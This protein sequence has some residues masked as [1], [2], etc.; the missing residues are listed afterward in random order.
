MLMH[1]RQGG[2]AGGEVS[3]DL[4]YRADISRFGGWLKSCKNF[5]IRQTGAAINRPG[6]YFMGYLPDE[7]VRLLPFVFSLQDNCV[8]AMTPQIVRFFTPQGPV[9]DKDANPYA[10]DTPYDAADLKTLYWEQVYDVLYLA[11]PNKPPKTLT[12]YAADDWKV[13]NY[14]FTQGP[15][16]P[17]DPQ[18][19]GWL[20]KE[21]QDGETKTFLNSMTYDFTS[22]DV[23]NIF[24]LRCFF[25]A[26][27]L[28]KKIQALADADELKTHMVCVG[29]GWTFKTAGT[30]NGEIILQYSEDGETWKDYQT[31]SS[32]DGGSNWS[33]TDSF[34][35]VFFLRLDATAV[36]AWPCKVDLDVLSFEYNVVGK[37]TALV[38][39]HKVQ[40]SLQDLP[41]KALDYVETLSEFTQVPITPLTSNTSSSMFSLYMAGAHQSNY[42]ST[43][44]ANAYKSLDGQDGT[45]VKVY[46]SG[47]EG[48]PTYFGWTFDKAYL[49]S[50]C[51]VT[52]SVPGWTLKLQLEALCGDEWRLVGGP[53]P[54][55][56]LVDGYY[57]SEW[58]FD[59]QLIRGLRL[60]IERRG[61]AGSYETHYMMVNE[62]YFELF[63]STV[64]GYVP[65]PLWEG[66]WSEKNGW[67][68]CVCSLQGRLA[69]GT[70]SRIDLS[71]TDDMTNF[72]T[73]IPLQDDDAISATVA[74]GG[75]NDVL[76]LIG[77]RQLTAL[78]AA[79]EFVSDSEVLTPQT[80][81]MTK[82]GSRGAGAARP[83]V[84][85][86]RILFVQS[87]ASVLRDMAYDWQGG[88][89]DSEDL[90][91][92]VR[93]LFDGQEI[94]RICYQQSPYSLVW[95][96]TETGKLYICTYLKQEEVLAWSRFETEGTVLDVCV[97][98]RENGDE[99][100]LAVKRGENVCLEKM[101]PWSAQGAEQFFVDCGRTSRNDTPLKTHGGFEHLNGREVWA[102]ADGHFVRAAVQNGQITL[103]FAAKTVH[104]GLAYEMELETLSP[105]VSLQDGTA[106]DRKKRVVSVLVAA[107]DS[108]GGY[109]RAG[110]RAYA[111][112]P[113]HGQTRQQGEAQTQTFDAVV[114]LAAS[115]GLRAGIKVGQDSPRALCVA[116]LLPRYSLGD[117]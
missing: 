101:M 110:E 7:N 60:A 105:D 43:D 115:S 73:S 92:C 113:R 102:L 5:I 85:G 74:G 56:Q 61:T 2:F 58:I 77:G 70:A 48:E 36:N 21:T 33:T 109:V 17:L 75:L 12:R 95:V 51:K 16:L 15:F 19:K 25:P 35:E 82:Q 91:V 86:N 99:L 59:A 32:A 84:V 49:C 116:A 22:A 83:A 24:K 66:A 50:G 18:M 68:R 54:D 30:W 42:V 89:Y 57:Q 112:R 117:A 46:A 44:T 79:A 10:A 107:V 97:L 29:G 93:H 47:N 11:C 4:A 6:T 52:Y 67:P 108:A 53:N 64:A 27:S 78:T 106:A 98:N 111:L 3:P 8:A 34:S 14:A 114:P 31:F 63:Q 23:G 40:V 1:G 80:P 45:A 96:L 94:K 104:A 55:W 76:H 26:Q 72:G 71:K 100:W 20:T 65:Q 41:N 13:E 38:N 39:E 90:T 88:G 37:V 87:G 69:W 103:P 9:L 28:S 81:G 62:F